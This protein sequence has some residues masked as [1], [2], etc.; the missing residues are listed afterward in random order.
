ML[1]LAEFLLPIPNLNY[2]S[3]RPES[4]YYLLQLYQSLN[5][6]SKC[7]NFSKKIIIFFYSSDTSVTYLVKIMSVCIEIYVI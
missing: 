5:V 3:S 2:N 1:L 7:E 6:N 4:E